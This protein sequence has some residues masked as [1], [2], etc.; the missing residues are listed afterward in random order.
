M[1]KTAL[2]CNYALLRFR[3]YVDGGE[4]VNV[5]LVVWCEPA[6]YFGY[7]CD[8]RSRE[9]VQAFFPQLEMT[10]FERTMTE[11]SAECER[12]R[13]MI[14]TGAARPQPD[15]KRLYQEFVRKREG[16]VTFGPEAI[17]MTNDPAKEKEQLIAR[18]LTP[19]HPALSRTVPDEIAA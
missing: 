5:G 6:G 8:T 2:P 17:V 4:F 16:L 12:L 7:C 1:N 3:P 19:T 13:T 11:M 18:H 10:I 14:V 9:R 15:G